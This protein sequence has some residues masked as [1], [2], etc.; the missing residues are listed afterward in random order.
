MTTLVRPAGGI[1]E[2]WQTIAA[3]SVVTFKRNN[4]YLINIIRI[5]LFPVGMFLTSFLAWRAAG[6]STIDGVNIGGFLMAGMF[7]IICWT[8]AV[9]ET[10]SAIEKERFE[11]TIAALYLTPAS[12]IA[13]VAGHGLGGLAFLIP[14]FA[15]IALLGVLTGARLYIVSPVAVAL[16]GSMMIVAALS[17]GFLLASFFILTRRANLMANVIQHPLY[18]LGGFIVP[19]DQLPAGLYTLSQLMPIAHA[20]DAFRT[21][22]LASASLGDITSSLLAT[23]LTSGLFV[24]AGLFGIRKVEHAAKRAGQLDFF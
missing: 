22:M 8:S 10:G 20:V 7:G 4:A 24:L 6:V 18:L 14:S 3:T 11:G 15:M 1:A 21:S 5:P 2:V 9:W 19:R 23:A 16:A 12:R 13:V 17:M